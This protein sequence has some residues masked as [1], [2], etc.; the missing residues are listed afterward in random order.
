MA[1]KKGKKNKN[2]LKNQKLK[3]RKR[4]FQFE[5]KSLAPFL[6]FG[7]IILAS[8]VIG[9]TL[10]NFN[11]VPETNIPTFKTDLIEAP[12]LR[13]KVEGMLSKQRDSDFE[14]FH[15]LASKIQ[16][17]LSAKRVTLVSL[18]NNTV[19]IDLEMHKAIAAIE[20]GKKRLLSDE[21]KVFGNY[22]ETRDHSLPLIKGI[23]MKDKVS[24]ADDQ[25]LVLDEESVQRIS[26]A[27]LLI[28]E[29]LRYNIHYRAIHLDPYRGFQV[30]LKDK[31]I[32]VEMGRTPF[33]KRY[34]KLVKILSNLSRKKVNQAR[35]ELDYQ[36]KAFIK[37]FTL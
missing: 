12:K 9:V 25:S 34:I 13:A 32:R 4:S 31:R 36:G 28:N 14:N 35:I 17:K 24:L 1:K 27:R 19:S 15:D 33:K 26:E 30:L 22:I 5:I 8:I 10:Q 7:G 16:K 21:G 37:E 18:G 29:G 11:F 20:F 6:P 3:K 2:F 23:G